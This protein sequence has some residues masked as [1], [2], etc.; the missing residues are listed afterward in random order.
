LDHMSSVDPSGMVDEIAAFPDHLEYALCSD[1]GL[2]G[3]VNGVC[4]CGMGG[5]AIGADILSDLVA[6]RSRSFISVVRG[7]ELPGWLGPEDLVIAVSYSG[8]TREVLGAFDEALEKRLP[9]MAITSGG[10]LMDRCRARGVPFSPVPGEYQPRAALGHLMGSLAC[11]LE[12]QGVARLSSEMSDLVPSL[13]EYASR[14]DREVPEHENPAKR[15]AR[16]LHGRLPVVYS[17]P[18]FRSVGTRWQ[19]QINE[20]AKMLA[21]SGEFPECNHNHIVGWLEG[22]VGD[23][24]RPLFLRAGSD[25]P[26]ICDLMETTIEVM[27]DGGKDPLMVELEGQG[28]LHSLLTG[29]MLGDWVSYYLAMLRGVDPTPVESIA[30]LKRRMSR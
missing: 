14:M 16:L 23:R 13:R 3:S 17:S 11:V 28:R 30:E 24:C 6:S 25:P 12:R 18:T 26:F 27:E 20:N 10:E 22:G 29:I 2:E 21:F 5:S 1:L 4:I 7:A 15:L 19:T 9:L 8:N